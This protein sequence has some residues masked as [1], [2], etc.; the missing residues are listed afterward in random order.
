MKLDFSGLNRI[1]LEKKFEPSLTDNLLY[2]FWEKGMSLEEVN[3][4]PIPYLLKI[5]E[6]HSYY[7]E[8]AESK[9]KNEQ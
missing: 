8:K 2:F 4:L 1:V 7:V 9:N 6:I 5:V 3:R